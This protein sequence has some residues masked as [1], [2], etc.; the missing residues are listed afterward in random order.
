MSSLVE[1][2]NALP[3]GAIKPFVPT[4]A[5]AVELFT[6]SSIPDH[7]FDQCFKM[8][9]TGMKDMYRKTIGWDSTDKHSEM[10]DPA[11]RY[12]VVFEPQPESAESNPEANQK[13]VVAYTSFMIT[14]E[15]GEE[16]LYW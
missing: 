13:T 8:L 16:V 7:L 2:H 5:L 9:E 1:S 14:E 3:L 10:K 15:E 6:S 11:M 12:L 4:T